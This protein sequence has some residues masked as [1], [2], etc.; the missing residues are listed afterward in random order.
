MFNETTHSFFVSINWLTLLLTLLNGLYR[1]HRWHVSILCPIA[2]RQFLSL[3]SFW[4]GFLFVC[5]SS[6]LSPC[7]SSFLSLAY[8][9]FHTHLPDLGSHFAFV[10]LSAFVYIPMLCRRS[11]WLAI[12]F[13]KSVT[14]WTPLQKN[15]ERERE[16]TKKD[17]KILSFPMSEAWSA[18]WGLHSQRTEWEML[19]SQLPCGH[20]DKMAS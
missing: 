4:K 12:C 3:P 5:F 7:V 14:L 8:W 6:S 18:V 2:R 19:L 11:S 9:S 15:K 16:R 17:V 10:F 1:V 13:I 20:P